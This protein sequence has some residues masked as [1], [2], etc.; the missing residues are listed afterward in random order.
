MDSVIKVLSSY[1][2]LSKKEV[3]FFLYTFSE[4]K[5]KNATM[6]FELDGETQYFDK[7]TF[8]LSGQYSREFS[9]PGFNIKIKGGKELYDR[10]SIKLRA[11]A[12][13]PT[14]LRT[15]L[16]TD[17][18]NRLGLKSISANY[19][20]LYINDEYMGLYI[21]TDSYKLRW[22]EKVYGEVNSRN[23]YKCVSMYDLGPRYAE[24]CENENE[25]VTDN[26]E[27]IEFLTTVEN[28]KSADDLENIFEIDHFLYE[29]AIEYLVGGWDHIY[30]SHN[31]FLYKQP[32]GKWIYLSHDN[33]L[34]IGT[35][36]VGTD[37]LPYEDFLKKIHIMKILILDD[38]LRFEK[39]LADV[40]ERV[41]NPATLYP[42]IDELK[43]FLRPFVELDKTPNASG[44]LPGA[45]NER[46]KISFSLEQWDAYSEFTPSLSDRY[47]Y[48]LKQWIL[49]KYRYVCQRYAMEC[50]AVYLDDDYE[51]TIVERLAPSPSDLKQQNIVIGEGSICKEFPREPTFETITEEEEMTMPTESID[52]EEEEGEEIITL[53]AEEDSSSDEELDF[54]EEEEITARFTI[55][56][57]KFITSPTPIFN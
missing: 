18:H 50:E 51:Y 35:L 21:L 34:D 23:L 41:F 5:T 44:K 36:G 28:A 12:I 2:H 13:E 9:K 25:E 16:M 24:D 20:Q 17:I 38:P 31:F 29:M 43:K 39:I 47:M 32:N 15:K 46:G 37:E 55:T 49:L 7:V 1:E 42:R 52:E 57:T 4:F 48:G 8:S 33:D 26:P 19:V 11:D 27:W 22:A 45:I 3:S 54:D 10:S 40:I 30:S 56:K 14:Y 53:P 6:S